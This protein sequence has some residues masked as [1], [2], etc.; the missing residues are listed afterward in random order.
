MASCVCVNALVYVALGGHA[1]NVHRLHPIKSM[2]KLCDKADD[3]G[4]EK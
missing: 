4:E 3:I 1:G 2:K